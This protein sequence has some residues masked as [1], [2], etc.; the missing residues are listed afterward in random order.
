MLAATIYVYTYTKYTKKIKVD[1]I[2]KYIKSLKMYRI[3]KSVK[4]TTLLKYELW[5]LYTI[6]I[7]ICFIIRFF[8]NF[9]NPKVF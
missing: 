6:K 1:K 5:N 3:T 8:E 9:E 2:Y 7:M 4:F